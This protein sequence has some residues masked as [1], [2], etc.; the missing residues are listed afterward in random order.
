MNHVITANQ[1]KTKGISI[2]AES[3]ETLI[4]VHGEAKYV[5][6]PIAQYNHFRECELATALAEA[7]EDIANGDYDSDGIENHLKRITDV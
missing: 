4:T 7:K 2:V 3:T 6:M 1:L 5:V